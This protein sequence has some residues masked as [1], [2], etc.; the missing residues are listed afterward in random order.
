MNSILLTP[1]LNNND[2]IKNI[3]NFTI[4]KTRK[5]QECMES[6]KLLLRFEY[7]HK[8]DSNFNLSAMNLEDAD[9]I[10]VCSDYDIFANTE[11]ATYI[12]QH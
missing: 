12:K 9:Y 11:I 2:L 1:A 4:T 3:D 10:V 8:T 6:E 5:T 7:L